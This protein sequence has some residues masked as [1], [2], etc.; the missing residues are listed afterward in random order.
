MQ[1]TIEKI[2]NMPVVLKTLKAIEVIINGSLKRAF[3]IG[4]AI[5]IA[6]CFLGFKYSQRNSVILQPELANVISEKLKFCEKQKMFNEDWKKRTEAFDRKW[7]N[8]NKSFN[9]SR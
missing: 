2:S 4:I 3:F 7:D 6:I 1:E 9:R 5:G 8:F